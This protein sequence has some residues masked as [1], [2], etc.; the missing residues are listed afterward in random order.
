MT[1]APTVTALAGRP[2]ALLEG[3]SCGMGS[4]IMT[5]D[6][7]SLITDE[8]VKEGHSASYGELLYMVSL[9]GPD[10]V[11]LGPDSEEELV[12]WRGYSK[13]LRSALTCLAMYE[14]RMEPEPAV[15]VVGAQVAHAVD[16]L[17]RLRGH[18]A[19]G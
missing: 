16:I 4:L 2:D 6:A 15:L 19:G 12:E 18:G 1:T 9:L 8:V 3:G 10:P 11:L 7:K 5:D 13:G 17:G 14:R